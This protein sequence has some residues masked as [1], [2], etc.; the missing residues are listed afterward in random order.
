VDGLWVANSEGVELI[1]RATTVQ[2]S[3]P[4]TDPECHSALRHRQTDGQT[5]ESI[6]LIADLI[7]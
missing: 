1:H 4:Y 5:D 3:T 2:L 6:M 7:P